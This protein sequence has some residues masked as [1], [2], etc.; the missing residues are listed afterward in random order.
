MKKIIAFLAVVSLGIS[1]HVGSRGRF[2]D[3][4]IVLNNDAAPGSHAENRA[5]ARAVA[6]GL[7]VSPRFT[8]GTALFGFSARV[9]ESRLQ[10]LRAN[11]RVAYIEIDRPV[12]IP[13]PNPAVGPPPGQG[14]GSGGGEE[15]TGQEVPW[16]IARIGAD[17]NTNEG[18]GVHVYV[19][20]T[21][22]DSDHRDL[23]GNMG[24]GHAVETCRG[25]DRNC[26]NPWDDDNGHGSHVA[27]TI[28][29]ID[30]DVDV[31]GVASQVTLHAVKVLSKSGSGTYA[32]VAAGVDWVAAETAARGEAS[33][34]NMSLGGSGSKNGTCTTSGFSGTGALHEA[35]CNAK[36]SGVVFVVA[37]GN[38]GTD[39]ANKVPAAYDDA[40]ITVSATKQGDDWPSWSNWGDESAVWTTKASAPVG[41]AAPGVSVLSTWKNGETNTISG[42]SMAT[43]HVAGACAL[44]LASST[45]SANGSAF[46]NTRTRLLNDAEDSSSFSNTS[47]RPHAEDFLNAG[48]L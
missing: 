46:S 42:T 34:A 1:L 37:A 7:G 20:D 5:A 44:F 15:A 16:G 18:G 24:N 10:G 41:I 38:E 33:V 19:I 36:N 2:V 11:P 35:L 40:V 26:I 32:G 25:N 8:Y 48:G 47:G 45:Q 31:L 12:S 17:S 9:P 28:G 22:I 14:P 27:G 3:V 30:N 6:L 13:I 43:P 39:A 21:G 4:I 29:A 23:A